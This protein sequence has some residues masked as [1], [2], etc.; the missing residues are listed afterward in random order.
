MKISYRMGGLLAAVLCLANPVYAK[1]ASK[2]AASP[3]AKEAAL[4]KALDSAMTPGEGQ[5]R[6]EPM[7][8]TFNVAIRTWVEPSKPPLESSGTMVSAWVLGN[9]YVQSMLAGQVNGEPFNGIGY[10]GFDNVAKA[11]Q[12]TWM[13]SGSTGM[14]WYSGGFD[15]AGKSATM[16]ASVPDVL[17]G[18]PSP[19][20][21]RMKLTEDG[22]HVTELWG[23][24]LGSTM[25]KMMELRYTRSK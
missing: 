19:M 4:T 7:I 14:T 10:I 24:G 23:K 3:P 9:R 12:A 13:D 16:K 21:L 18:K 17:T 8:G 25:F 5:K 20:E 1:D 11:Y 22:G 6:L 15:A 2:A